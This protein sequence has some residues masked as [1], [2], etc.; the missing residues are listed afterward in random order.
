VAPTCIATSI[1]DADLDLSKKEEAR[2]YKIDSEALPNGFSGGHGKDI[3][4]FI[5]APKLT[6]PRSATGPGLS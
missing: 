3:L 1:F 2:L 4:V 6:E 5:N